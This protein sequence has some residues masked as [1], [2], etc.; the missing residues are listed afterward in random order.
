MLTNRHHEQLL[1]LI[2]G[3]AVSRSFRDGLML[4]ELCASNSF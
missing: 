2:N 1:Q 3:L 4:F